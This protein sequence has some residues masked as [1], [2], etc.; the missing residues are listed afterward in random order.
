MLNGGNSEETIALLAHSD[1]L[2][3]LDGIMQVTIVTVD[4]VNNL[5]L[6]DHLL[7]HRG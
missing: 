1:L 7:S 2:I 5:V 4:Q 6:C 3:E